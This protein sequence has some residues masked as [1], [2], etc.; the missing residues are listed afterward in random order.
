MKRMW[1]ATA[2]IAKGM[3]YVLSALCILL[4]AVVVCFILV[5]GFVSCLVVSSMLHLLI[6]CN[7]KRFFPRIKR[8]ESNACCKSNEREM[9][10]KQNP[11]MSWYSDP[12]PDASHR[13]WRPFHSTSHTWAV[14]PIP[15]ED[16]ILRTAFINYTCPRYIAVI[17][18]SMSQSA[19]HAIS[20]PLQGD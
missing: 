17:V 4:A 20:R 3:T 14:G 9:Y 10:V 2:R 6:V 1:E 7:W 13:R 16:D 11:E 8:P 12:F 18:S 19:V 5:L 15:T